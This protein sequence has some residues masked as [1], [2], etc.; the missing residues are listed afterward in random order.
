MSSE[1]KKKGE[2]MFNIEIKQAI[3][4]ARLFNYEVAAALNMH[5][6]TFSRKISRQELSRE[7]KDQILEAITKT[8]EDNA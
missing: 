2:K 3:K 1:I 6:T 7:E 5:E 4:K 8:K